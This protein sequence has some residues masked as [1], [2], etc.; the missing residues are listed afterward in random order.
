MNLLFLLLVVIPPPQI[1]CI[2]EVH[3]STSLGHAVYLRGNRLLTVAHLQGEEGL[4]WSTPLLDGTASFLWKGRK[5]DLALYSINTPPPLCWVT[6]SKKKPVNGDEVY[7]KGYLDNYSPY[8]AKG[9]VLGYDSDGE[10][11]VDGFLQG[12]VS[13]SGVLNEE[14]ELVGI[15]VAG[16]NWG[17]ADS[18]IFYR[19]T[20]SVI[21]ITEDPK[22]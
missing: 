5:R 8:W 4:S 2:L 10:I 13:G 22:P 1:H 15:A 17:P 16:A 9:M 11:Q 21:P 7:Y 18:K 12:G 19:S 20:L 14:G 3:S 6:I